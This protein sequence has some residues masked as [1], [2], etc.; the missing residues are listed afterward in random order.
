MGEATPKPLTTEA[1]SVP[2][3]CMGMGAVTV[4]EEDVSKP[5]EKRTDPPEEEAEDEDAVEKAGKELVEKSASSSSNEERCIRGEGE[6]SWSNRGEEGPFN[7]SEFV[8][9]DGTVTLM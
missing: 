3:P 5:R 1:E 8:G 7:K 4:E 9:D 6:G 2:D